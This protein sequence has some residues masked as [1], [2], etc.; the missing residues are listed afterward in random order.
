MSQKYE[1]STALRVALNGIPII[2][3]NLEG[4]EA[5]FNQYLKEFKEETG[6]D[7]VS[8]AESNPRT[9]EFLD[10]KFNGV[11]LGVRFVLDPFSNF[12]RNYKVT[13]VEP[14]L[15]QGS[16]GSENQAGDP[17]C[18]SGNVASENV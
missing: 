4:I 7:L 11:I 17:A 15:E 18:A 13:D 1:A 8:S 16:E 10:A 14:I 6:I 9:K 5:D 3:D 12:N 2:G